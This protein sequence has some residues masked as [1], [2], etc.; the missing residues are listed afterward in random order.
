MT[1]DGYGELIRSTRELRALSQERLASK[2]WAN[3]RTVGRWEREETRPSGKSLELLSNA[4]DIPL[5]DLEKAVAASLAASDDPV[6]QRSKPSLEQPAPDGKHP[7]SQVEQ[8][9]DAGEASP[10]DHPTA[11]GSEQEVRENRDEPVGR[12]RRHLLIAGGSILALATFLTAAFLLGPSFQ[13]RKVPL[14]GD[15]PTETEAPTLGPTIP[16][17]SPSQSL[18]STPAK[19]APR[20]VLGRDI[21]PDDEEPCGQ[22]TISAGGAWVFG[23]VKLDGTDY[24]AYRCSMLAG[25]SGE[26][27]FSLNKQFSRLHVVT[28][29]ASGSEATQHSVSFAFVKEGRFYFQEPFELKYGETRT[30]ELNVEGVSQLSIRLNETSTPGGDESP[31]SPV[32]ASLQL[33]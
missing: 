5:E 31:S 22:P 15:G 8:A 14:T 21:K 12:S 33:F 20:A 11:G 29:F 4:L 17:N 23:T 26:L 2:V 10:D 9:A 7:T 32:V 19:P 13:D 25:A 24:D 30:L 6:N 28:G 3:K 27:D 1:A 18:S 16:A